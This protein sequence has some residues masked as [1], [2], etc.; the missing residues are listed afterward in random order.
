MSE[1]INII[2][3]L[4]RQLHKRK[5]SKKASYLRNVVYKQISPN[6]EIKSTKNGYTKDKRTKGIFNNYVR[7][8]KNIR[9]LSE[10]YDYVAFEMKRYNLGD[11]AAH[12]GRGTIL[13]DET[14]KEVFQN[15]NDYF[16]NML[17]K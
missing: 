6:L 8:E 2:A 10:F 16:S 1:L 5:P 13:D 12:V 9:K 4:D 3:E 14:R 7:T 15:L 17:E 11:H